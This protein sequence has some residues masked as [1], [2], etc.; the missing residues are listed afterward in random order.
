MCTK[1]SYYALLTDHCCNREKTVPGASPRASI[2][3]VI[4]SWPYVESSVAVRMSS[5]GPITT[6]ARRCRTLTANQPGRRLQ[7]AAGREGRHIS[8][9]SR[10]LRCEPVPRQGRASRKHTERTS[11]RFA[12]LAPPIILCHPRIDMTQD[13]ASNMCP[14]SSGRA[15]PREPA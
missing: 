4:Y 14:P 12:T 15:S 8:P 13:P 5:Y 10:P 2:L 3:L 7:L 11:A 6:N 9:H 1:I